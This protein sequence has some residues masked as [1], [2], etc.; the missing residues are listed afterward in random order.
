MREFQR[1]SIRWVLSIFV[2]SAGLT[3]AVLASA[4]AETFRVELNDHRMPG[5]F[6]YVDSGGKES[7][8]YQLEYPAADLYER[9]VV[10]VRQRFILDERVTIR[11][12]EA[13]FQG[14]PLTVPVRR[15]LLQL[16][17]GGSV[18]R[19]ENRAE[20][21]L[22]RHPSLEVAIGSGR[23]LSTKYG[24]GF[25]GDVFA[26]RLERG[27]RWVGK[28][29]RAGA[30]S[31]LRFL[32]V[33][34]LAIGDPEKPDS[35][36]PLEARVIEAMESLGQRAEG[37]ATDAFGM[38]PE[39]ALIVETRIRQAL[40][41][42]DRIVLV[43]ASRGMAE[44]VLAL[45]RVLGDPDRGAT[46]RVEAVLSL[47]G[48]YR[49]SFV[50][51]W[52]SMNPLPQGLSRFLGWLRPFL[53]DRADS[54]E[55]S[56]ALS[57]AEIGALLREPYA[58][59]KDHPIATWVSVVGVPAGTGIAVEEKIALVQNQVNRRW[60]QHHGPNDGVIETPDALLPY[61]EMATRRATFVIRGSHNLTDGVFEGRPLRDPEV[62]RAWVESWLSWLG[63]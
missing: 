2:W 8:R 28:P 1:G 21:F 25:A 37:V 46:G 31:G 49:G 11:V 7:R 60:I 27:P 48:L 38:I 35:T 5:A 19:E 58:V 30:S 61:P 20:E 44:T 32:V 24:M 36:P 29:V 10:A 39:N 14:Q 3:V 26:Q 22:D 34:G 43:A 54:L 52:L 4:H 51:D 13:H 56:S 12:G 62:F 17:R 63:V 59:L 41:E 18:Y 57:H 23:E 33:P 40:L 53:G 45:S 42:G 55:A 15:G 6:V 16:Q 47:N 9:E 50:A